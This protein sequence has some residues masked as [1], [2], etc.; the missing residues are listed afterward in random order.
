MN[1]L[2]AAQPDNRMHPTAEQ[3]RTYP[4]VGGGVTGGINIPLG[5]QKALQIFFDV[6]GRVGFDTQDSTQF[7]SFQS[8][9]GVSLRL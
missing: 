7:G 4:Y 3:H 5:R 9:L 2:W 8:G 6:G 1:L